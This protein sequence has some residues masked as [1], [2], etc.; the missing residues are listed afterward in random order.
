MFPSLIYK[1]DTVE[2]CLQDLRVKR[3]DFISV[4]HCLRTRGCIVYAHFISV[5]IVNVRADVLVVRAQ[6]ETRKYA[7]ADFTCVSN[8]YT[9][10]SLETHSRN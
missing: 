5:S 8:V 9:T 7:D 2:F 6:Q 1:F 4:S 10:W 3:N